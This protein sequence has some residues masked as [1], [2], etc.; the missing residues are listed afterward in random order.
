MK[1]LKNLLKN[2]WNDESAQGSTEYILLIV[3]VVAIVTVLREPIM[4]AVENKVGELS[5]SITTFGQ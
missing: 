2:L 1:K 5:G 4:S 3:V